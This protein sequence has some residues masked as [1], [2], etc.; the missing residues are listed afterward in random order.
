MEG[1][2]EQKLD[3]PLSIGEECKRKREEKKLSLREVSRAISIQLK[4]L[5]A[6]EKD[7]YDILPAR[8]YTV[9]FLKAYA[10]FLG[11]HEEKVAKRFI[12][13]AETRD[14][15]ERRHARNTEL[16]RPRVMVTPTTIKR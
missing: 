6:I 4:Y 12:V 9:N 11:L 2:T 10:R 3:H 5:E 13:Q 1:F 7:H 15:L 14:L 8:V 16:I